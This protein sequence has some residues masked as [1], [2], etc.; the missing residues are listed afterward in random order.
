[1]AKKDWVGVGIGIGFTVLGIVTIA[2]G[3]GIPFILIGVLT[4]LLSL[5]YKGAG[6]NPLRKAGGA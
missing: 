1:M 3:V 5:G 4:V 2:G 6:L